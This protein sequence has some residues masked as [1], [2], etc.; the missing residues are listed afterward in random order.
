MTI[1][2]RSPCY[3]GFVEN[4]TCARLIMPPGQESGH[5]NAR[6]SDLIAGV[7]NLDIA[8]SL[9]WTDPRKRL[10]S[11]IEQAFKL[12]G[13]EEKQFR[14]LRLFRLARESRNKHKLS[15]FSNCLTFSTALLHST[16]SRA[17][18][19]GK[20]IHEGTKIPRRSNDRVRWV[21]YS[22]QPEAN[23]LMTMMRAAVLLRIGAHARPCKHA[24]THAD[25]HDFIIDAIEYRLFSIVYRV[26]HSA[27]IRGTGLLLF[28][29]CVRDILI[30]KFETR[31]DSSSVV[32]QKR[33]FLKREAVQLREIP[34]SRTGI[35]LR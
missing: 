28:L 32:F 33:E 13:E 6:R 4:Y 10:P 20:R 25:F 35:F 12:S 34:S 21:Q 23:G 11:A 1:Q 9:P 14:D 24:P 29:I 2:F 19:R 22:H 17:G 3:G 7:G 18:R 26:A 16:L 5:N 30:L 15:K 27:F 31:K 8:S